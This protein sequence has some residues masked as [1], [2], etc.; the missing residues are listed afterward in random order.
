MNW[1]SFAVVIC[2]ADEWDVRGE[3]ERQYPRR[4]PGEEIGPRQGQ[5]T[6][7]VFLDNNK[8]SI[9]LQLV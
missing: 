3:D 1:N 7:T 5:I 2:V 9:E 6:I 4:G 8:A